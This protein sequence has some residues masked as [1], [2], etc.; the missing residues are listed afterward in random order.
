MTFNRLAASFLAFVLGLFAFSVA[1]QAQAPAKEAPKNVRSKLFKQVLA[2]YPDVRECVTNEEGGTRAAEENM[3]AEEVDLN[4]DGVPEYEVTLSGSCVCGMVNCSIYLYRQSLTGYELIL[5]G[6]AGLGLEVLKTAS[7][8]YAD[9]QVDARDNA[10]VQSQTTYK[11]DGKQYK[12]TRSMLVHMETGETKPAFRRVQ[13]KRGASSTTVQG[14][15]SIALPDTYLIGAREGQ[16]MTVHLTAPRQKVRFLIMNSKT[17]DVL[18]DNT[19]NW[20]GTLPAT[21]DYH[22]LVD[23]DGDNR[24]YSMTIT[25]K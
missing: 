25:I 6:A 18:A 3:S 2:D 5:D 21:G 1:A 12:E 10:A 13:F 11:F 23:T 19:T 9:V 8:G 4:R 24:T 16:V 20:T 14:K 17:T 22:I 15:V 7:N